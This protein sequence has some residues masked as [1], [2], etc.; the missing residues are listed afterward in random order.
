M[1]Y[2][3]VKQME[4]LVREDKLALRMCSVVHSVGWI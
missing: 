3:A 4:S 1:V 2:L